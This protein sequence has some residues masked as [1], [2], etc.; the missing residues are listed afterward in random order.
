MMDMVMVK[1]P[2]AQVI[3]AAVACVSS[4]SASVMKSLLTS[5]IAVRLRIDKAIVVHVGNSA[6]KYILNRGKK[7]VPPLTFLKSSSFPHPV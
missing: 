1:L 2:I 7:P 6:V 4:Q 3:Q 5:E